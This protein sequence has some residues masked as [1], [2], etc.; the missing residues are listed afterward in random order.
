MSPE[1]AYEV[2]LYTIPRQVYK[3]NDGVDKP[4]PMESWVFN[5][6][7]KEKANLPLE[8]QSATIEF[9]AG[10]NLIKTVQFSAAA[11]NAVRGVSFK[12][13][14]S[15][16][17]S[18]KSF[19]AQEESFDLR[20]RFSEPAA[21]QIDRLVYTLKL[22][23]PRGKQIEKTLAIPV[24][25]YAQKTKLIFPL[26]G[27]FTVLNGHVADQGHQEWSQHF[28]YDIAGLGPH[29]EL[30]K[31]DGET[32][33]DWYGWGREILAPA[34][35]A[36][37]Y[38]RNDVPDNSRPGVFDIDLLK[39]LPEP[40]WAIGGNCV[41]IDHGNGEFSFL[42]HMQKGSVLVKTGDR[43]K[44]GQAIGLLGSSGRSQAPHLHYHLMAGS[45]LF[46]SDGLPSRFENL[47]IE[48]PKRGLYLEAK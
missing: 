15:S 10:R 4:G 11:L 7:V 42:A 36:V 40:V 33:G 22:T 20:H 1:D 13:T 32:S 17:F 48:V 5:V 30:V 19:S 37:I 25:N 46:R 24:S 8:P 27:P 28:A 41:V 45:I 26:K 47:E 2:S 12:S 39:K 14:T 34:G 3:E 9:Y 31:T 35:G 44:Q 43:V 21:L 23:T 29:L 38:S 18:A 6:L 16:E